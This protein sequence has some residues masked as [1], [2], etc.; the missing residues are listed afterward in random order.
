M[1]LRAGRGSRG[2]GLPDRRGAEMPDGQEPLAPTLA[3]PLRPAGMGQPLSL[4]RS[5]REAAERELKPFG[6]Q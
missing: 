6:V 4:V 3:G 1:S 2:G 5:A